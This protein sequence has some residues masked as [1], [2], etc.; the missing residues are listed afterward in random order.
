MEAK[1]KRMKWTCCRCLL[2][3]LLLLPVTA[4]PAEF[5]AQMI[6]K[7]GDTIL[8][9]KIYVQDGLMRQEFNDESGQTVTVVRPDK[10]VVWVILPRERA[11]MELPLKARLP[12][13]F[14]QMPP[15]TV[16]KRLLGKET[17][18][19]YETEKYQV[20]VRNG[21]G[22]EFQ[23]I[24]VAPKLGMPLKLV[25]DQRK[26]SMEYRSIRE[27]KQSDRWFALPPGYKKV[28]SSQGFNLDY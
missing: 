17:V 1:M 20:S 6:V 10:R 7:D 5:S 27:G 28:A 24:W 9:G 14:I 13:Q 26:F 18:N 23:T 19:G 3:V 25:V 22:L 2:P 8:P 11:Y 21:E 15:D 4:W 12:G 16:Q